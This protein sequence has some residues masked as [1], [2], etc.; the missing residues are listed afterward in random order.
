MTDVFNISK[1]YHIHTAYGNFYKKLKKENIIGQMHQ[2]F[3]F[4]F[5][6]GIKKDNKNTE[7]KNSDIFQVQNISDDNLNVIKGIAL[8]KIDVQDGK[9]LI[10][11]I[12]NYADGG[13]EI[14]K[15]DYGAREVWIF[16]SLTNKKK[17]HKRSDIDLAEVGILDSKFYLKYLKKTPSDTQLVS[18]MKI[19]ILI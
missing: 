11:E 12:A 5:L 19:F 16:G 13:I 1:N 6:V 8:M 3:T 15:K 4:A 10:E 14:L 17:F 9:K 7:K 18:S 2:L